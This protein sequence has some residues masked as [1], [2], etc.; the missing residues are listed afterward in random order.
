MAQR[1]LT[2]PSWPPPRLLLREDVHHF[3]EELRAIDDA[4]AAQGGIF[5]GHINHDDPSK[6]SIPPGQAECSDELAACYAVLEKL[7][8]SSAQP[9]SSSATEILH[10]LQGIKRFLEAALQSRGTVSLDEVQ[11]HG[12]M[13]DKIDA[14]RLAHGGVFGGDLKQGAI[15]PGQAVLSSLLAN[16]YQLLDRLKRGFKEM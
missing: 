15:P 9:L 4:R 13:L 12:G 2:S 16:N 8:T 7:K 11:R 10:Q 6:T 3:R 5:G 14:D 1:V